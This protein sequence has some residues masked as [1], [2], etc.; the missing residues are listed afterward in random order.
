MSNQKTALNVQDVLNQVHLF[1]TTT[2]Q[3]SGVVTKAINRVG[4]ERT[5]VQVEL[6]DPKHL[7]FVSKWRKR[8][9]TP[10]INIGTRSDALKAIFIPDA[11]IP[12]LELALQTA[13]AENGFQQ[14]VENFVANVD[15]YRREWAD[16]KENAQN[17]DFILTSPLD[18]SMI[19]NSFY[20]SFGAYRLAPSALMSKSSA[21]LDGVIGSICEEI[22]V[23][24]TTNWGGFDS[25]AKGSGKEFSKPN[26]R[27]VLGRVSKKCRSLAF[28]D[29]TG[30]AVQ[31]A[32]MVDNVVKTLP[33]SGL[34]EGSDFLVLR[35]LMEILA[36]PVAMMTD[37]LSFAVEAQQQTL[38]AVQDAA[39]APAPAKP[40][41]AANPV[42]ASEAKAWSF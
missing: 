34:I 39:Q 5:V 17:R 4:G 2:G 33:T 16:K 18:S 36:D 23:D 1:Y 37:D 8:V 20:L 12:E 6:Y 38:L 24:V 25:K 19:R 26:V 22:R 42:Q 41:P 35:S 28:L 27:N 15:Q 10:A 21:T 14:D 30:R 11:R 7:S 40:E 3:H 32:D 29:T 13:D 31:I 9:V